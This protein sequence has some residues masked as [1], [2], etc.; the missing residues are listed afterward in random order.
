MIDLEMIDMSCL[1][2]LIPQFLNTNVENIQVSNTTAPIKH[3]TLGQRLM[4][5]EKLKW[6]LQ[7]FQVQHIFSKYVPPLFKLLLY[8]TY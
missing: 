7:S 8:K 2:L 5:A 3:G 1:L 6:L 4:H